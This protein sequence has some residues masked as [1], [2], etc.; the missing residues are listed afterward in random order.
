M[1][2]AKIDIKD[3]LINECLSIFQFKKMGICAF[4]NDYVKT[5]YRKKAKLRYMNADSFI[6][7]IKIEDIYVDI[8]KDSETRF[9]TDNYGFDR[10]LPIE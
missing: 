7:F 8:A 3:T 1:L 5:K 2:S 6:K 10:S 4:E 9:D